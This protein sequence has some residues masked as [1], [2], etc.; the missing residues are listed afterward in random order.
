M[1]GLTDLIKSI[2]DE[3]IDFQLLSKSI[4]SYKEN[5]KYNDHE[6]TFIT[7]SD[8][9]TSEKEAVILWV[10]KDLFNTKLNEIKNKINT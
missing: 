1:A 7:A 9:I 3:S 2:G 8:K 6:V 5:K 4:K 10:D